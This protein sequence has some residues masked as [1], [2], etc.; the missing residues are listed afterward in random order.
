MLATPV[1]SRSLAIKEGPYA[2][3]FA[4]V[5]RGDENIF[6]TGRAGSGKTTFLKGWIEA[7]QQKT[8][9]LAPTGIAA[10]NAGGQTIHSFFKF[11]PRLLDPSDAKRGPNGA[12][13]R[14][15]DTMVIDEASMVRADIMDA[16]DRSMRVARGKDRPFGGVRMILVGDP[17]Q[18]PPI[19]E[20]DAEEYFAERFGGP[21]FFDAPG[22]RNGDFTRI[23]LLRVFRQTELDFLALLDRVRRAS[24]Q[25]GDGQMLNTRIAERPK[26]NADATDHDAAI[27]LTPTNEAARVIN[28]VELARLPGE[29]V[30]F[31]GEA[32]GE[33]DAKLFPVDGTLRLK[34]GARVIL[35]RNDPD[36]RWVNGTIG[37]VA[38]LTPKSIKVAVRGMVYDVTQATWERYRYELD[39]RADKI[40]KAVVGS[41]KQ[42]PVRLAWALT[43][44]KAQGLTFDAVHIDFGRGMFAHG[45][46]YVALSRCRT[47]DGL[48]LSRPLRMSDIVVDER[49]F[50][51]GDEHV[52]AGTDDYR[53]SQLLGR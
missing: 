44:H 22:F 31:E 23:E 16:M 9:V 7:T 39:A 5:E 38:E 26:V 42:F 46:A 32:G 30:P 24:M 41:F 17:A 12:I 8:V 47:L 28:E 14:K 27:V 3:V 34:P 1:T 20:R 45:Q 53:I 10:I 2:E 35:T 15:I 52:V 48:T 21:Y 43:V 19:V 13:I 36:G 50:A 4:R 37:T 40:S 11:P 29:I 51:M 49:A 25:A 33:F 18:L 6:L